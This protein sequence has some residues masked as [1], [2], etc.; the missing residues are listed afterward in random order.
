MTRCANC[1]FGEPVPWDRGGLRCAH[2]GLI[3]SDDGAPEGWVVAADR[4]P[5]GLIPW[6]LMQPFRGGRV[7]L[8]PTVAAVVRAAAELGLERPAKVQEMLDR[9]LIEI[10]VERVLDR[11]P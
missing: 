7:L 8:Q 10:A 11:E 5:G 3:H 9:E 2:C 1:P 6:S 4:V